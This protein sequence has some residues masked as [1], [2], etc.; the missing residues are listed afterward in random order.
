[1]IEFLPHRRWSVVSAARLV[2]AVLPTAERSAV[3]EQEV[4]RE[5]PAA[6]ATRIAITSINRLRHDPKTSR[7]VPQ[8]FHGA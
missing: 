3:A 6:T 8:A 1:M 4:R 5:I 2:S 7:D